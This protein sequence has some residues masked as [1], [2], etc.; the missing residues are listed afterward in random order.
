MNS[1]E[2]VIP[3]DYKCYVT[4]TGQSENFLIG[5]SGQE[6]ERILIF[7]RQSWLESQVWYA[8]GTCKM[9]PPL[10]HQV[11][12][13]S[14]ALSDDLSDELKLLL[15]WF[16]YNYVGRWKSR[17]DGRHPPLFPTRMWNQYRW[18]VA[19]EDRTNNHAEAA[20]GK[21]YAEL[22]SNHSVTWKFI[23]GIGQHK[24]GMMLIMSS[25]LLAKIQ[26][27]NSLNTLRLMNALQTS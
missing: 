7:G 17:G 21:G 20:Q 4:T 8:D 12:D 27:K 22:G 9:S 18:T 25:W 3:N 24:E 1:K 23:E 13:Y 19:D 26:T 16:E 2:L 5:D 6:D 11:D 15:N 10:F 14:D